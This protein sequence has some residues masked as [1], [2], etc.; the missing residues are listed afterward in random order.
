MIEQNFIQVL[1]GHAEI[2][3]SRSCFRFHRDGEWR[4]W[5]Y[6]QVFERVKGIAG[7]IA[8]LGLQLGDRI[9][10]ISSNRPEWALCDLGS[11]CAGT[12][13]ATIY[14]DLIAEDVAYILK[15]SQSRLVFAENRDQAEKIL[16]WRES[17]PQLE[18]LVLF[19]EDLPEDGF[20]IHLSTLEAMGT[21][22]KAED[23]LAKSL[24]A[25][26]ETPLTLI[27]TS[28]TTGDPKGVILT[29][30][31]IL[32]TV[33]AVL[34]S[35]GEQHIH[36]LNL[37]F[38]PLA[39]ALERV[40]G[41]YSP[42]YIGGTIAYAR[43]LESLAEDFQSIKPEFAITVPRFFE[44]LYDRI[45]AAVES[46]S[47][48]KRR[49]F[50]WAEKIGKRRSEYVESGRP[51]PTGLALRFKVAH[52]L[53]FSKLTERLG[54]KIRYFVAG[55]APLA[56]DLGR[57]F[58]AADILIC[59]GYGATE[60]SAPATLNTPEAYRFG[61]VGRSLPGT[62]IR[63]ASDGELLIRGPGV[64]KG[65][66]NDPETT[67]E[68]FNSEGFYRSGDIGSVDEDGYF[69]ITDRKKE[70]IIT[71]GGKNIAPT[72][73]ENLLKAQPCISNAMVHCDR[74]PYV[75][76]LLT[77]DRLILSSS[78]PEL[79]V[80]RGDYEGVRALLG[81]QV[82][83]VNRHLPRYEQIKKFRVIDDDFS[84]E[85]GELTLTM[86]LKRRVIEERYRHLLDGMYEEKAS[87]K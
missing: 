63:I 58:H 41:H 77:M 19:E 57:F 59:E 33:R 81:E 60:T 38:L 69:Y 54:G 71:A 75:V 24:E 68:A 26:R 25:D 55:G 31:N 11:M 84:P 51:V 29:H 32:G 42:I 52:R 6:G 16:Y 5:N 72:K 48:I 78:H 56:A 74:R 67:A 80:A 44:K 8:S 14:P 53:V 87:D 12:V 45:Q 46:G 79:A 70:L 64:F 86:K 36:H 39:H 76:A 66:F 27:Y 7:G 35:A 18:H 65:Y 82:E 4:D 15:H 50:R 40:G 1:L 34:E 2:Q 21:G 62:E 23:R 83:A 9:S 85:S 43:D 28:G 49:I 37:S 47:P 30:G 61:S 13:I 20:V 17:L 3:A 10:L 73:L 22:E